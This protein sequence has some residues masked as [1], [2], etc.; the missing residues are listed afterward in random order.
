MPKVHVLRKMNPK[1]LDN[2]TPPPRV[3]H[4]APTNN[5]PATF[6]IGGSGDDR[7]LRSKIAASMTPLLHIYLL[8]HSF[9]FI[10]SGEIAERNKAD[11]L[12]KISSIPVHDL[13]NQMQPL[14][15]TS[16]R[17]AEF[18]K[19]DTTTGFFIGQDESVSRDKKKDSQRQY[20]AMLENDTG[21]SNKPA[22]NYGSLAP[23]SDAWGSDS[24]NA[25]VVGG[26][27]YDQPKFQTVGNFDDKA[28]K[29]AAY[30]EMLQDQ[31]QQ[32]YVCLTH[33][34]THSLNHSLTHSL[35]SC[36]KMLQQK[37]LLLTAELRCLT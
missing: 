34:L 11:I 24:K 27:S 18:A 22:K 1:D 36:Q 15:R 25:F 16:T 35:R 12:A 21:G 28:S 33:S 32:K 19:L 17:E 13:Y 4:V 8:I 14:K 9:I 26:K 29:Q 10:S 37:K 7:L 2:D 6:Q 30:R 20:Y 31:M 5:E 3:R 23:D